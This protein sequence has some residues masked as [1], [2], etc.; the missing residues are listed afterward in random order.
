[1]KLTGAELALVEGAELI[2]DVALM[3]PEML[4][5]DLGDAQRKKL[6]WDPFS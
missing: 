6:Q 1:V 5:D 2:V 3:V 4:G